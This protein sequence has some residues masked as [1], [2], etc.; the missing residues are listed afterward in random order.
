MLAKAL[1][2]VLAE[3]GLWLSAAESCTGGYISNAITDIPGSSAYTKGG[4]VS[5]AQ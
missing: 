4:I 2:D 5:Y 3:H 1:G